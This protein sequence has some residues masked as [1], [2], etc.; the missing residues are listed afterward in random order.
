MHELSRR[1][2]RR[3]A[4]RAQLLDR[5]R[6]AGLLDV[7]RQLTLLQ[8][9]PTAAVAPSADLV[10]VE[11]A[12]LVLR[13]GRAGRTRSRTGTLIELRGMIRPQE[14]LAL[15]R[16]EMAG[17]EDAHR[18]A[19]LG[20]AASGSG[21]GPT[22]VA[23]A[24]SSTGSSVD[25]PLPLSALPDTSEVPVAVVGLERRPQRHHAAGADG[26]ARRGRD[27]RPA[28]PANACGTWPSGSTPTRPCPRTRRCASAT[29]GGCAR[30]ASPARAGRSVRW[31]RRTWARWAN[32]PSSRGSGAPGG[33]TRRS[34]AS[35]SPGGRR[36]CPRSTG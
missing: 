9:D 32:R 15:Y 17:W 25:G 1:D 10:A 13:P 20:G 22:T 34:W 16:A 7:V 2:A 24:T 4:V 28:R 8:I 29:S 33:S 3:I 31:S 19:R 30:W 23:G 27:R 14:D 11:P 26:A 12:R 5:Q 21:C 18:A 6:P 35:R 36:C